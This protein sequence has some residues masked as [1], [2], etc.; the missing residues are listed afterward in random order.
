MVREG[1]R[2]IR[3]SHRWRALSPV[4]LRSR[5]DFLGQVFGGLCR[6]LSRLLALEREEG[7]LKEA[8]AAC[9]CLR[10]GDVDLILA[11]APPFGS[12]RLARRLA[13]RLNRPYVLDY[14][15]LWL[16]NP[17]AAVRSRRSA[18]HEEQEILDAA[19]GVVAISPSLAESLKRQFGSGLAVSVITNGYDLDDLQ[20]IRPKEFGHFAVVYTGGFY[21]P[22]RVI[23]P[24]METLQRLKA[25]SAPGTP[26]WAFHYYGG[27][28]DHV[29]ENARRFDVVDK[30]VIHG[31]VPRKEALAAVAGA[32][33]SVVITSV[34]D[35]G[36]LADKGVITGK[37]FESLAF[38]TPVLAIA[39]EGSDLEEVLRTEAHGRRF[40]GGEIEEMTQF[41][42]HSLNTPQQRS[43]K[44]RKYDWSMLVGELD[45]VL[46]EASR[47]SWESK[48]GG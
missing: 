46:R 34:A 33:V 39:P 1:I 38:R 19:A 11:T 6:R 29:L 8:S 3:T 22:K 43:E 9:A 31:L 27:S 16:G 17:H 13:R 28:A 5:D 20:D 37:I 30:V 21:P 4:Q 26:E 15:D 35:E 2:C 42:L 12:L 25:V 48:T 10:P 32:G 18:R 47:S 40:H 24:I 45:G 14:R 44:T 41:L 36:T 23:T 7:W